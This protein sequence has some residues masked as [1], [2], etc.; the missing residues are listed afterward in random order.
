MIE[1]LIVLVLIGILTTILFK[2]YTWISEVAFRV[3]QTKRV[4]QET[5][6]LAQILQNF[7]DR[8]TIDYT[9]YHSGFLADHQGI[10]SDLYLSG[11]DGRLHLYTSGDCLLS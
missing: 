4:H 9:Q 1:I 8:N 7:V 10:V 3:E 2:S 5:L 6:S 11:Q